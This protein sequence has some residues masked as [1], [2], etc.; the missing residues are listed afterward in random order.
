MVQDGGEPGLPLGATQEPRDVNARS[1]V[2]GEDDQGQQQRMVEL[3]CLISVITVPVCVLCFLRSLCFMCHERVYL[4]SCCCYCDV[5][6]R[7]RHEHG[8]GDVQPAP[9][10]VKPRTGPMPYAG[11]NRKKMEGAGR[12]DWYEHKPAAP[13]AAAA[14]AAPPQ[15]NGDAPHTRIHTADAQENL[16][17]NRG[18]SVCPLMMCCSSRCATASRRLLTGTKIRWKIQSFV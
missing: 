4:R 9:E 15:P 14:G 3:T 1:R 2:H 13:R 8:S 17:K 10:P 7:F 6:H 18:E 12:P 16:V 5:T 11:D